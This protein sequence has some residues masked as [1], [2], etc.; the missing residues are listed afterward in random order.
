MYQYYQYTDISTDTNINI[1]TCSFVCVLVCMYVC[2][3]V[4]IHG[5]TIHGLT[6]HGLTVRLRNTNVQCDSLTVKLLYL[7]LSWHILTYNYTMHM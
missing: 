2:V 1:N 5:L 3:Y 4:T 7:E 6:I